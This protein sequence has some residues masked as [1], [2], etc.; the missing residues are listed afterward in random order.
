MTLYILREWTLAKLNTD[1][2]GASMVE[3]AFLVALIATVCI[4]ALV[5]LGNQL[6]ARF[7]MV[8]NSLS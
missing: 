4:A 3:Y 5:F 6:D 2:R 8:G 7:D 1:E